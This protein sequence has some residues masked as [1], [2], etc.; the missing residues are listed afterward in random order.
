[1]FTFRRQPG[2]GHD[3]PSTHL[4]PCWPKGC[5]SA[6]AAFLLPRCR[7]AGCGGFG[8]TSLVPSIPLFSPPSSLSSAPPTAPPQPLSGSGRRIGRHSVKLG[9]PGC[10]AS[11]CRT[12][13]RLEDARGRHCHRRPPS[14]RLLRRQQDNAIRDQRGRGC[15]GALFSQ[16]ERLGARHLLRHPHRP[17]YLSIL[18]RLPLDP[19]Q[20]LRPM[21]C[22]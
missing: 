21:V 18:N 17:H 5:D 8:R 13:M 19:F 22:C 15:R 14:A 2:R 9:V 7:P 6:R 12:R 3:W 16:R 20:A 4:D 1:M 10:P 11:M